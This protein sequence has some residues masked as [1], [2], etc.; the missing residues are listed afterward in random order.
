MNT[1]DLELFPGLADSAP[2][3]TESPGPLILKIRA[4]WNELFRSGHPEF[5]A[6]EARWQLILQ[7]WNEAEAITTPPAAEPHAGGF[8]KNVESW[9]EVAD[10]VSLRAYLNALDALPEPEP[11]APSDDGL[12]CED[13]S[14]Q[15]TAGQ[16]DYA[17]KAFGRSLCPSCQAKAKAAEPKPTISDPD[18]P[19]TQPQVNKIAIMLKE[20]GFSEMAEDRWLFD[21]FKVNS[22]K[23]LTKGQAHNAIEML[24]AMPMPPSQTEPLAMGDGEAD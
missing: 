23:N 6:A 17:V 5:G 13:C 12:H 2:A 22:K 11:S 20:K 14:S 19:A 24:T 1:R 15:V 4:R 16:R 3:E 21:N 9:L 10:E 7:V 8:S 18:A